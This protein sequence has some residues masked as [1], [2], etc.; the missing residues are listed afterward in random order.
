MITTIDGEETVVGRH[1]ISS[2]KIKLSIKGKGQQVD[3]F[4]EEN[5]KKIK[6]V[7]GIDI[8][9]LSTVVAGGFVGCTMGVYATT[10]LE[11]PGFVEFEWL[12][13][14]DE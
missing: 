6:I 14:I 10:T 2:Q 4:L 7:E 11:Q 12:S 3:A 9:Y 5:N 13:L 8:R 1:S